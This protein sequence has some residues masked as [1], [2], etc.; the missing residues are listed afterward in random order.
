MHS[1]PNR[2]RALD[3]QEASE[4]VLPDIDKTNNYAVYIISESH[5]VNIFSCIEDEA[6]EEAGTA[7]TRNCN[8]IPFYEWAFIIIKNAAFCRQTAIAAAS[9][10]VTVAVAAVVAVAVAVASTTTFLT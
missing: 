8:A 4:N 7:V 10:A 6:E 1:S 3:I 5:S 9:V 2:N